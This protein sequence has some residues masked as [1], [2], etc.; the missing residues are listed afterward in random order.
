MFNIKINVPFIINIVM[1]HHQNV[2]HNNQQIDP[3][4]SPYDL[5]LGQEGWVKWIT[6]VSAGGADRGRTLDIMQLSIPLLVP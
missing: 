5:T 6:N 2:K 4:Q 3:H 1:F